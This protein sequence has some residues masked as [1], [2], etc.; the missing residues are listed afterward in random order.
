M[1]RLNPL[2][3]RTWLSQEVNI[4]R[5]QD[6][7][8]RDT[9]RRQGEALARLQ[10]DLKNKRLAVI[11]GAGVTL[12]ATADASGK[13]LS[14]ITWT[15]L[16]RNGLDL[17]VHDG[18]V[19]RTDCRTKRAYEALDDPDIDGLLDAANIL[20]SQ[21]K[22]H[23]QFPTWLESVFGSLHQDVRHPD[24]LEALKK[25]HQNGAVLLTTNYD[26]VLETYCGLRHIGRS[27]IED[28]VKFRRGNLDGVF[29][30]HG[31]FHDPQE[32]VLDTTDYYQIRT[33]D[34]VQNMLK[35]FL[36][37]KTI[38]FVGCGSGLEDPNFDGLLKWAGE[39]QKNVPNHHCLL[40]RDGDSLKYKPLVR[41]KYGSKYNDLAPFLSGLLEQLGQ[42]TQDSISI[43]VR[44]TEPGKE[45]H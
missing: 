43:D 12:S 25:L 4:K 15:G 2:V 32:V 10:K 44:T 38:L 45:S 31:S 8:A 23:G 6:E 28:I 27:K 5:L 20:S 24:I 36:D 39:R 37:D 3:R 17:L 19:D 7:A 11:V 26:D 42:P 18:Y 29:H 16:I 22:Q 33:S 14:R 1:D 9:A 13:P 34:E 30:V 21:L 41:L 35:A 40:I